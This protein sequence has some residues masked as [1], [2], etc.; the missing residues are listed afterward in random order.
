MDDV[1]FKVFM[2][3]RPGPR[4]LVPDME[5]ERDIRWLLGLGWDINL[6]ASRLKTERSS[7]LNVKRKIPELPEVT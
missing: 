3:Q 7:V 4:G 2:R 5:L 6:I 1:Y